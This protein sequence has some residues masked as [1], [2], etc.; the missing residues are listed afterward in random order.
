MAVMAMNGL[1]AVVPVLPE[2]AEPVL[3]PVPAGS[4][5]ILPRWAEADEVL[6]WRLR[7]RAHEVGEPDRTGASIDDGKTWVELELRPFT[8]ELPLTGLQHG[9][10]HYFK[11]AIE[12][13]DG[14]S[15]WSHTVSAQP[16]S[17]GLP[18]KPAA[19]YAIVKDKSTVLVRWTRPIDL[20][21]AVA[22]GQLRNYKLLVTWQ[23]VHQ[24]ECEDDCQCEILINEDADQYEVT[25]LECCRNYQFQVAAENVTGW[26]PFSDASPPINVPSPVPPQLGPPTLRR[27]THHSTVIQ[28]Q[29]PPA[30]DFAVDSFR[31]R[32]TSSNDFESK[33]VQEVHNVP[34]NVS[35]YVIKGLLPGTIYHFQ[36]TALNRYGM[37]I[38]SP[39]SMPLQTKEGDTP[40]KIEGL[41]VLH[42]CRS[43]IT[44][45]WP[46]AEE[47]GF[48]VTR[49]LLRFSYSEDMS[50]AT[51][52]EPVVERQKGNDRTDLRHLRKLRYFFQVASFNIKGMSEWSDP[53]EVD[54]VPVP[55]LEDA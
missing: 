28:W 53:V 50:N 42:L 27:P 47:R 45:E 41:R 54:L 4:V 7:Y 52:L 55:T 29:H 48:Q 30:S 46:P 1:E 49:H 51:E 13:P 44:L 5:K 38:W 17:P 21:A 32:Y 10:M 18:G 15:N 25:D 37:G 36:V 34:P 19:V 39:S 6:R 24:Q 23:P 26:G 22:C 43:F 11:V 9:V 33:D 20:A 40:S 16:P 3:I 31:F 8:R 35:Q 2:A 12:T 14:W